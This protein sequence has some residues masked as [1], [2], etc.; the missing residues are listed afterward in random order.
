MENCKEKQVR[1][2]PDIFI[3]LFIYLFIYYN[4]MPSI[5]IHTNKTKINSHMD[6]LQRSPGPHKKQITNEYLLIQVTNII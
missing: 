1:I 2:C 4:L 5:V 6:N 3:Y